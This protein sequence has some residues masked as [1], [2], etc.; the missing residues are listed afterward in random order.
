MDWRSDRLSHGNLGR[1]NSRQTPG[2]YRQDIERW[3]LDSI[4]TQGV[5]HM[6]ALG[7]EQRLIEMRVS[8]VLGMV[9]LRNQMSGDGQVNFIGNIVHLSLKE[10]PVVMKIQFQRAGVKYKKGL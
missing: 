5:N 2:N 4:G 8:G 7:D 3:K 6:A 10:R 1:H 9:A